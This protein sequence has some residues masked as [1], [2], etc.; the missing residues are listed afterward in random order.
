MIEFLGADTQIAAC[1]EISKFYQETIRGT[2]SE[3]LEHFN[4]KEPK[5]EFVIVFRK[6]TNKT[7]S[8]ED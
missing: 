5:G 8:K 1:R 6:N 7:D 4:I 2:A 3:V